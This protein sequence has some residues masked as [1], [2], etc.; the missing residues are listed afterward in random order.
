MT[1]TEQSWVVVALMI[2]AA[3]LGHSARKWHVARVKN[4]VFRLHSDEAI[5]LAGVGDDWWSEDDMGGGVL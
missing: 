2:A 3:L 1:P 4:E 5:A